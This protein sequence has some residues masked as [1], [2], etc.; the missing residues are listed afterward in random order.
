MFLPTEQMVVAEPVVLVEVEVAV[1]LGEIEQFVAMLLVMEEMGVVE[2]V[3]VAK[4]AQAQ[5]VVVLLTAFS[6]F[7]LERLAK[8][9]IVQLVRGRLE[10]HEQVVVVAMAALLPLKTRSKVAVMARA[11]VGLEAEAHQVVK[12]ELV[13]LRMLGK[14]MPLALKTPVLVLP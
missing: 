2:V 8:S 12:E 3:E 13:E 11:T 10:L 1:V 6:L 5:G 9:L 7:L 4:V 14:G